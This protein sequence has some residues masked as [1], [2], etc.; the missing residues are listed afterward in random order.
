[1]NSVTGSLAKMQISTGDPVEYRLPL[2]EAGIA[3]NPLLGERVEFRF[4][5]D[6]SCLHCGRRTK[7]SYSQGFCYPCFKKLPQCDLCIMSPDRCH[8]D[9]GT[10]RDPAWAQSFCFQPHVVYLANSTGLKVGITRRENLPGRWLD[11]GARQAIVVATTSTRQQCGLVERALKS[12]VTDRTD[13]R[14]LVKGES[15][16]LDMACEAAAMRTLMADA[17][18]ELQARFPGQLSWVDEPPHSFAF[19]VVDYAGKKQSLKL[20]PDTPVSGQLRGIKG[21]YLLLDTGVFNV[22]AHTSYRVEFIC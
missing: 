7:K 8:Y 20:T 4:G 22:R 10:C 17:F 11:Q 12:H 18:R 21:Q 5:G 15:P 13:W 19:P 2:T 3:M 16:V 1:M 14:A 9:A 6:I